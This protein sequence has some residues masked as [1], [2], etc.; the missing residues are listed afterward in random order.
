[1]EETTFGF[2]QGTKGFSTE[3]KTTLSYFEC[4]NVKSQSR[5]WQQIRTR[6]RRMCH[7]EQHNHV[8]ELD[9]SER[10]Y[11]NPPERLYSLKQ[12]SV[13]MS[14]HQSERKVSE[15]SMIILDSVPLSTIGSESCTVHRLWN[16]VCQT[17]HNKDKEKKKNKTGQRTDWF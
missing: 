9:K 8:W 5:S 3:T 15:S 12:S 17:R 2:F 7:S 14:C 13:R 10:I 1:M 4:S 11:W 16:N 6:S